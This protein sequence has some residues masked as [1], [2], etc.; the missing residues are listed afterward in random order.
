MDSPSRAQSGKVSSTGCRN[1]LTLCSLVSVS[2]L[3]V[4]T[5]LFV[6]LFEVEVSP[7]LGFSQRAYLKSFSLVPSSHCRLCRLILCAGTLDPYMN[8]CVS[9]TK[10]MEIL[11]WEYPHVLE[12]G[13]RHFFAMRLSTI[14]RVAPRLNTQYLITGGGKG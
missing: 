4:R 8:R 3:A 13:C 9:H 14:F 5:N 6:G 11:L 12:Y 1:K 10:V 2:D 7:G